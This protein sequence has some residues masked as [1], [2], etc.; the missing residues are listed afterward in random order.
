MPTSGDMSANAIINEEFNA[1]I[2]AREVE[3]ELCRSRLRELN[4]AIE[5]VHRYDPVK[6]SRCVSN[7]ALE[8][9]CLYVGVFVCPVRG[10]QGHGKVECVPRCNGRLH[11]AV[12]TA[13]RACS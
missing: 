12:W 13:L 3:L 1:E 4:K 7:S 8:C 11:G 9:T 2:A 10:S 6:F 5:V